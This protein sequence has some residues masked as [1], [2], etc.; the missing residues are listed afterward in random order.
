MKKLLNL[1]GVKVLSNLEQLAM[2][3][4]GLSECGCDGVTVWCHDGYGVS[5]GCCTGIPYSPHGICASHGGFSHQ[6]VHR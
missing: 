6:E 5:I 2:N 4:E 3:G 1:K